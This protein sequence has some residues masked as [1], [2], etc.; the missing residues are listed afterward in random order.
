MLIFTGKQ[1]T[2]IICMFV[3]RHA[4][5]APVLCMCGEQHCESVHPARR[6]SGSSS[7]LEPQQPR[8]H[9]AASAFRTHT[10]CA[11]VPANVSTRE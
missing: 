1:H 8:S 4:I 7:L 3:S 9:H 2:K 10:S 5:P 6:S 11:E